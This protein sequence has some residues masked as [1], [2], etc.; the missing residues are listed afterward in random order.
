MAES[1]LVERLVLQLRDDVTHGFAH[2]AQ[3][4]DLARVEGQLQAYQAET[5]RRIEVLEVAEHGRS[6]GATRFR[7]YGAVVAFLISNGAL[8]AAVLVH[9]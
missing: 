2:T 6:G 1:E 7:V 3:A 4:T 5:D 8:W 9:H